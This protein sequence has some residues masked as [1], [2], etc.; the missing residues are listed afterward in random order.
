MKKKRSFINKS[1]DD[2]EEESTRCVPMS[3]RDLSELSPESL[4][5]LATSL[6]IYKN[7]SAKMK[8]SKHWKFIAGDD[9]VVSATR[10]Y[11]TN[12]AI[13]HICARHTCSCA[14]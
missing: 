7:M 1:D 2:S 8:K 10:L 5:A 4:Q 12:D 14:S 11:T 13:E 6:G 3:V 9:M